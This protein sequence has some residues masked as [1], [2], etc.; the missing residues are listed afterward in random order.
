MIILLKILFAKGYS[1]RGDSIIGSLTFVKKSTEYTNVEQGSDAAEV[2]KDFCCLICSMGTDFDICPNMDLLNR[3][4]AYLSRK[5]CTTSGK[6]IEE[7]FDIFGKTIINKPQ[8]PKHND[9]IKTLREKLP[10]MNNVRR[11]I[12]EDLKEAQVVTNLNN[13]DDGS[14]KHRFYFYTPL[15]P[16]NCVLPWVYSAFKEPSGYVGAGT[17][18]VPLYRDQVYQV[19]AASFEKPDG[20]FITATS[21]TKIDPPR[22]LIRD[23]EMNT[24]YVDFEDIINR[25]SLDTDK[26]KLCMVVMERLSSSKTT[27]GGFMPIRSTRHNLGKPME[28]ADAKMNCVPI[29]LWKLC[30]HFEIKLKNGADYT[31][32]EAERRMPPT[33]SNGFRKIENLKVQ[34]EPYGYT[35]KPLAGYSQGRL[36][37]LFTKKEGVYVMDVGFYKSNQNVRFGVPAN[38]H[39]VAIFLAREKRLVDGHGITGLQPHDLKDT[40]NIKKDLQEWMHVHWKGDAVSLFTVM[41]VWEIKKVV[42]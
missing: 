37:W 14:E 15:D 8:N 35:M 5:E 34:L 12:E 23:N 2:A 31:L 36:E 1:I 13:G 7:M 16:K 21:T 42:K 22:F 38:Q 25:C 11:I 27:F 26:L 20:G 41:K 4:S 10:K 24:G 39:H 19:V 29:C 30:R 33:L 18:G 32:E 28:D 17:N 6:I 40:E 9:K 3:V